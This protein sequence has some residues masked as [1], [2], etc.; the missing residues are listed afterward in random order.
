MVRGY[1][2]T[3]REC[4]HSILKI[5]HALQLEDDKLRIPIFKYIGLQLMR[6]IG[7][8]MYDK[9]VLTGF[10]SYLLS[11][12]VALMFAQHANVLGSIDLATL[13]YC[14]RKF[15]QCIKLLCSET[16]NLTI[17]PL[18]KIVYNDSLEA[19]C[20]KEQCGYST[21]FGHH[22]FKSIVD[23]HKTSH[24]FPEDL[25]YLVENCNIHDFVIYDK[26]YACFL[27]FL[28]YIDLHKRPESIMMASELLESYRELPLL[29]KDS[30]IV[31]N[32][33][34]LIEIAWKKLKG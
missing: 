11:S 20:T 17:S 14:Q 12:E 32:T 27:L 6:R 10:K 24:L 33:K 19:K 8:I 28:I 9:F 29:S 15:K 2:T 1:Q 34:K 25:K 4:V 23:M 7:I 18:I 5:I 13:W 31:Q 16:D 22:Y 30:I 21:L 3:Y 26:S